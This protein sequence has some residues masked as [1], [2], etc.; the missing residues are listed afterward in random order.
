MPCPKCGAEDRL[1]VRNGRLFRKQAKSAGNK[2]GTL[3]RRYLCTNPDCGYTGRGKFFNLP[4]KIDTDEQDGR[5][6][7]KD[8]EE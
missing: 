8:P 2:R 3:V 4:E 1:C 5:I 7:K 6:K